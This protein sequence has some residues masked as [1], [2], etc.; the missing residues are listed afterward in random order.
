MQ[1]QQKQQLSTLK[2]REA[3][4]SN[5]VMVHH[6]PKAHASEFDKSL[7]KVI[8][9]K[10]S[11]NKPQNLNPPPGL[12]SNNEALRQNVLYILKEEVMKSYEEGRQPKPLIAPAIRNYL[13]AENAPL[14]NR[15]G[16]KI[17]FSTVLQNMEGVRSVII[18]RPR[19]D[20]THHQAELAFLLTSEVEKSFKTAMQME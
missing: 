19:K 7:I 17:P 6:E 11:W 3:W 1:Q 20:G 10:K 15:K 16:A 9:P 8:S 13:N 18:R 4:D 2:I 14:S 12:Y 5:S